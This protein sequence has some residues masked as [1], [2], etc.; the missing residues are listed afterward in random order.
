MY[1][2]VAGWQTYVTERGITGQTITDPASLPALVRASDYIK[3][4][5]V[6]NFMSKYSDAEPEVILATYEAACF[7][8]TKPGFFQRTVTPSRAS[9]LVAT[10]NIRW[11]RLSPS[12]IEPLDNSQLVPIN[13]KV[14]MFLRPFMRMRHMSGMFSVG[15]KP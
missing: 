2:T 1:G 6:A 5:Y 7:E 12:Q 14:E 9:A 4:H 10:K 13:T 15:P 11:E 8:N 3:Y